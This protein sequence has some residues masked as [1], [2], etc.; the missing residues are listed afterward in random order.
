MP[1]VI[2]FVNFIRVGSSPFIPSSDSF[3]RKPSGISITYAGPG[4]F[5]T[6]SPANAD[7]AVSAADTSEPDIADSI[8]SQ[9]G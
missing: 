5:L 2:G 4:S 1:A 6:G 8:K 7:H 9:A 3:Q